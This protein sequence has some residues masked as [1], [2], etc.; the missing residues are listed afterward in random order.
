MKNY[1]TLEAVYIYIERLIEIKY[2]I[3]KYNNKV[4]YFR[5]I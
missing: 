1:K 3:N 5:R 4:M 2:N